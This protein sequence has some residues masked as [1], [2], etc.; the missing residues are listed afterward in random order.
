MSALS[1]METGRPGDL[2]RHAPAR[3]SRLSGRRAPPWR[4]RRRDRRS[5]APSG[6]FYPQAVAESTPEGRRPGAVALLIQEEL[7]LNDNHLADIIEWQACI[8]AMEIR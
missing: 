4:T 3:A 2:A 5:S 7:T 6:V 1:F 8:I